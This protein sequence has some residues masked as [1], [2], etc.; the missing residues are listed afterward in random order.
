MHL[1]VWYFI[2]SPAIG[3]ANKKWDIGASYENLSSNY[4]HLGMIGLRLAY[5]FGL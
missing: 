1:F 5:G 2:A 3:Y 4:S